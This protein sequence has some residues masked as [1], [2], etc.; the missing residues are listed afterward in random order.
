MGGASTVRL[1]VDYQRRILDYDINDRAPNHP[2]HTMTKDTA[3]ATKSVEG[4]EGD[5]IMIVLTLHHDHGQGREKDMPVSTIGTGLET[6]MASR[7]QR[8]QKRI[9]S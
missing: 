7:N 5:I 2:V 6:E 3:R 9:H 1:Q 8:M 4:E